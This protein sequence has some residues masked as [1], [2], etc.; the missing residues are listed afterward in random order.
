[1]DKFNNI[2]ILGIKGVAM[3]NLAIMLKQFGKNVS[4]WDVENDFP[5]DEQLEFSQINYLTD[6]T[7][8]LPDNIDL[9]IYSA[10]HNGLANP[11][12][13]Q[14]N[15]RKIKVIS[16]PEVLNLIAK[17][18]HIRAAVCGCHGKTTTASL[19]AYSLINL[20]KKPGY[21]VGTSTFGKYY[22][23]D[24]G[25]NRE[26][27]VVEADEYG[28]DPPRNKKPK[29][30]ML[31]P[32]HII[33]NNI[34]FD[35]PDVYQNISEVKNSFLV[36]FNIVNRLK[37][38]KPN[39]Y[40]CFDDCNLKQTIKNLPRSSY[41]TYGFDPQS[42][43][44]ISEYLTD[45][46][47][48]EFKLAFRSKEVGFFRTG[49][50][51]QKNI[52]NT[53]GAIL[54]LLQQGFSADEIKKAILGFTGA[55]RRFERIYSDK[56]TQLFDDYAHHPEEIKTTIKAARERFPKKKIIVIF[57]PHT[58]SRTES[59]LAGFAESLSLADKSY[60]LPVFSSARENRA[61]F[62][63][64]SQSIVDLVKSNNVLTVP[65]KD[66]LIKKLSSV[67]TGNDVIFT[68]GAGDVYKLKDD[69]IRIISNK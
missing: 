17:K 15:K 1:M 51:G 59:L 9:V 64:S 36:F 19:L 35:H 39:L 22:G 46:A 32:T 42:D 13:V 47:G 55:K 48:V 27:F 49:L 56:G 30:L 43:L 24:I 12:L 53:A 25:I 20:G 23:G 11:L 21:L 50:Y 66:S 7:A 34:D 38:V 8:V 33:C 16:Q 61:D 65:T 4:G 10:A 31:D 60:I 52:S 5:T 29:M 26:Y 58:Y 2:F 3:A 14:A 44:T 68:M 45:E 40:F 69:I 18:Y 6:K 63:I 41:L 62:N 37:T 28:I 54:F 67:L 57:Q